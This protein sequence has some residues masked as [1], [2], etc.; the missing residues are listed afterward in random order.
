MYKVI[1]SVP[2]ENDLR[3]AVSYISDTLKNETAAD[4]LVEEAGKILDSLAEMPQRYAVVKDGY[5][6]GQ[7]IRMVQIKNYLAFYVVRDDS[8]TVTVLRFLYARRD[9]MNILKTH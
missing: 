3:N 5:L 2:A 1:V 4:A 6:A 9:W 8:G 7:G